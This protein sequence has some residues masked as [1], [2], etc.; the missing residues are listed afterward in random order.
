[1][2]Y[3]KSGFNAVLFL[4]DILMNF[5]WIVTYKVYID[6]PPKEQEIIQM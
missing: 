5:V 1:M 3:K 4:C 6:I 2:M